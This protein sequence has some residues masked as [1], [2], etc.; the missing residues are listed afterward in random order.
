MQVNL[1]GFTSEEL[2]FQA[3]PIGIPYAGSEDEPF[4]VTPNVSSPT[5]WDT[6]C[7]RTWISRTSDLKFQAQ[8]IGIPYAGRIANYKG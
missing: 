2:K 7:R 1:D 5:D 8:P 6:L 3:Q 4:T